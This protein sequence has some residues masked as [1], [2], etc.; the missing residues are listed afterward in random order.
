MTKSEPVKYTVVRDTREQKGWSF[1]PSDTCAGTVI[2]TLKTGDY[3][4]LGYE[5]QFVV[6]RKGSVGEFVQ[7]ITQ[8]EKWAAFKD[9][10]GR[11]EEFAAPFI[12]LE[13]NMGEILRYPEGSG[14]PFKVRQNIRISPQFCLKRFL[15]I[16]LAFKVKIIPAGDGGRDVFSSLCKRILERWPVPTPPD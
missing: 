1:A 14:L 16:E 13:F 15:E 5:R 2:G 8:K 6:E 9:E 7:N 12:I 11:L 4:L 10:L 3:S